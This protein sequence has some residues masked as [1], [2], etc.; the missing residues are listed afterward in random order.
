MSQ[1]DVE[2]Y[3]KDLGHSGVAQN[4]FT[5][6]A[7]AALGK[8]GRFQL[9]QPGLWAVKLVQG[10]VAMGASRVDFKLG[11]S[12]IEFRCYG[13]VDLDASDLLEAALGAETCSDKKL[14]NWVTAVRAAIGKDP[15]KLEICSLRGRQLTT[16]RMEDGSLTKQTTVLEGSLP[17]HRL[18]LHLWYRRPR[19]TS[20]T[21]D[22]YKELCDR[23]K[24]CPIVVSVDARSVSRQFLPYIGGWVGTTHHPKEFQA[25]VLPSEGSTRQLFHS[26]AGFGGISCHYF[27]GVRQRSDSSAQVRVL[28]LKDGVLVRG[29]SITPDNLSNTIEIVCS[30]DHATYD[31]SEWT[32]KSS[33]LR[34][35][36]SAIQSAARKQCERLSENSTN[37]QDDRP[38]SPVGGAVTFGA[39]ASTLALGHPGVAIFLGA[40]AII[41]RYLVVSSH[42]S[43]A[44][45]RVIP[46][47]IKSF[48]R[49][50]EFSERELKLF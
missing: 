26:P 48:Q 31:L 1:N 15:L 32:V 44:G 33:D 6:D 50:S 29:S 10:A 8:L 5:M 37:I 24:F 45:L 18:S 28:W 36:F 21:A 12:S 22:E 47:L 4:E 20:R 7:R 19:L 38:K 41:G 39:C 30:A 35:P 13:Q 17:S 49:L 46:S 23:C 43:S 42:D 14:R 16:V 25:F 9:P 27:V 2:N 40:S 3:L 34:F 11:R